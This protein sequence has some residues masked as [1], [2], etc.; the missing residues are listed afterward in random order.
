MASPDDLDQAGLVG[1]T[2]RLRAQ[3]ATWQPDDRPGGQAIR[4]RAHRHGY[5]VFQSLAEE[6]VPRGLPLPPPEADLYVVRR[7][8]PVND[9]P[10]LQDLTLPELLQF[11]DGLDA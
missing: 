3:R 5:A 7:E 6:L 1:V 11:L 9:E 4:D 10:E 2:R 8:K